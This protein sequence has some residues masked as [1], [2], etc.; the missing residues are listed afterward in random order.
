MAASTARR[1]TQN[2]PFPWVRIKLT[3]VKRRGSRT[4]TL[5]SINENKMIRVYNIF[6]AF[7]RLVLR[8]RVYLTL[9][10]AYKM[11]R[12]SKLQ[13]RA[14]LCIVGGNR[15]AVRGIKYYH[16]RGFRFVKI[17]SE[18]SARAISSENDYLVERSRRKI[19]ARSRLDFNLF[20]FVHV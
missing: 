17:S 16:C 5:V 11:R 12:T 18:L 14:Q 1:V 9:Y 4:K 15:S 10:V 2:C 7:R 8:S 6:I 13:P 20:C 3:A 19:K